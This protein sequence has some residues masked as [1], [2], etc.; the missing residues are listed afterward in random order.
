[1]AKRR[2]AKG[3]G[4]RQGDEVAGG[5]MMAAMEEKSN[6]GKIVECTGLPSQ[7][8]NSYSASLSECDSKL[9]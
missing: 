6:N 4:G 7:S 9:H 5:G 3:P 1:M 8:V 2:G